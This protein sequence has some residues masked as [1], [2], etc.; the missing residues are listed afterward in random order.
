MLNLNELIIWQQQKTRENFLTDALRV[1]YRYSY[2]QERMP[3]Q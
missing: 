3:V 1:K 2:L